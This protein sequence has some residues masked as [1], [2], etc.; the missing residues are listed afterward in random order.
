MA[1]PKIKKQIEA[2][3]KDTGDSMSGGL[4]IKNTGPM[5]TMTNSTS[6]QDMRLYPA[7]NSTILLNR[8]VAGDSTNYR[9]LYL[10]NSTASSSINSALV[11]QDTING[12]AN[13]YNLLHAG[14]YNNYAPTKGGTGATG[15]W[16]ISISGNSASTTL[17]KPSKNLD[18]VTYWSSSWNANATGANDYI[19]WGQSFQSSKL[20]SDTGDILLWLNNSTALNITIDGEYYATGSKK[21]LHEGN[22]TAY[23]PTKTGSGASGTWGISISGNAASA[24]KATQDGNGKTISSTYLP[25]SNGTLSGNLNLAPQMNF[26]MTPT[27]NGSEWSFDFQSSSYTGCYWHVWDATKNSLLS[28]YQD[29]GRV[30]VNYNLQVQGKYTQDGTAGGIAA[31]Q[32]GS[33]NTKMLWAY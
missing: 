31:M 16:G 10:H 25:V 28:V 26:K 14:N 33:P 4:E 23:V 30:Q 6:G 1:L 21:V 2:R 20:G 11:L 13:N 12:A 29:D 19:V 15:T 32:S 3:V 5:F 9:A 18:T 17:L 7:S 8:N 27:A 22:Y 24:T